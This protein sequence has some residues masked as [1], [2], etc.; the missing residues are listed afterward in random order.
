MWV[1]RV[2]GTLVATVSL[3]V[4]GLLVQ[5]TATVTFPVADPVPPPAP[6]PPP[7][8]PP[9]PG[10]PVL[11]V[12]IDNA[13][14]ARPP[15][16]I[17]AADLIAVEPVEAG[18]SRLI[19]VFASDVPPVVG[20][21]RSARQTDLAFLPQFGHPTLAFSGAA[22]ELLPMI[23]RAPVHNASQRTLPGAFYR[24]P[25]SA[26]HNMFVRTGSLPAG[27]GWSP[28]APLLFGPPP[29]TGG[30]PSPHQEVSYQRARIGFDWSP[31][32]GKWLVSFDGRPHVTAD[33]GRLAP[34]TVV[35]QEVPVTQSSI[36]DVAG[37]V[38]PY[39][40]TVGG[41]R[42]VVLRDGLAYNARWDRPAPDLGTTYTTETGDPLRFAPGQ[43]WVVLVPSP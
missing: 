8:P 1:L 3:V 9:P 41:G 30:V 31:A 29:A 21:V 35:L 34:S 12:K 4:A 18:I 42:A 5:P 23:D 25:G 11:A 32:E 6:P 36:S 10:P 37:N 7:P 16:G 19:A 24:G 40:E 39:A 26:P 17:G 43:V 28:K 33:G 27:A 2:L 14:A 22:P 15:T 13:P 38:S 20:P